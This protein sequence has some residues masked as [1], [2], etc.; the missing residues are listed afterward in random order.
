MRVSSYLVYQ[1][2]MGSNRGMRGRRWFLQPLR[3]AG[4]RSFA[5]RS[6]QMRTVTHVLNEG[7]LTGPQ[8]KIT[9]MDLITLWINNNESASCCR[10]KLTL[11]CAMKKNL[12]QYQKNILWTYIRTARSLHSSSRSVWFLKNCILGNVGKKEGK[13]S[14]FVQPFNNT[15]I[16]STLYKT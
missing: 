14:L 12:F 4:C 15:E 6:Q 10:F 7:S 11:V 1:S 8:H 3:S 9:I 5:P 16:Q 2:V 13:V